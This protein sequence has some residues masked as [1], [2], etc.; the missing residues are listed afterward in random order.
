MQI[1]LLVRVGGL[2]QMGDVVKVR[3][4]YARNFLLPKKKALRATKDNLA[5]FERER[6]QLEAFNLEQKKEAEA[7]AVKLN[8]KSFVIIRQASEAGQLYGSVS[9]RD[10]ADLVTEGGFTIVRSQVQLE[11]PI[12]TLGQH[13][14]R[15]QL[16]PEVSVSVAINVA[17][18]QEEAQRMERGEKVT[19]SRD[20]FDDE[21]EEEAKDATDATEEGAE[22]AEGEE[23]A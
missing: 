1:I 10:I 23:N 22:A 14:V 15:L 3:D 20:N 19:S 7:V 6:A 9:T 4:G 21:E 8:G 2:G 13:P 12:K 5:H 18:T 17:R 16:H 11:R